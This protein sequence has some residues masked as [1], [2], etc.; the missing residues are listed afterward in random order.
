MGKKKNKEDL[1][2]EVAQLQEE[3]DQ[4]DSKDSRMRKE[5]AKSF[6]WGQA[7]SSG[8]VAFREEEKTEWEVPSWEQIFRR[9]GELL[10]TTRESANAEFIGRQEER[11]RRIEN[12]IDNLTTKESD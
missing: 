9:V 1:I 10:I 5:F 7:R 11:L 3:L 8:Y 12:N 6:G 4:L 2:I